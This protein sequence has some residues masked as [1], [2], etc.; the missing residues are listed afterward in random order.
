MARLVLKLYVGEA[1]RAVTVEL[2]DDVQLEHV[3]EAALAASAVIQ[4]SATRLG[5][6]ARASS[7]KA[8]PPDSDAT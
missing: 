2:P 4:R 6:G 3:A 1:V 7:R 5:A 8:P